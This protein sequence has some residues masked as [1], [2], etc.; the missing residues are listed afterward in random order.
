MESSEP[1]SR[2]IFKQIVMFQQC[3]R[4]FISTIFIGISTT[5]CSCFD[6]KW[7][8]GN[9]KLTS[10]FYNEYALSFGKCTQIDNDYDWN[11]EWSFDKMKKCSINWA[12]I[13]LMKCQSKFYNKSIRF[14]LFVC[15]SFESSTENPS[16]NFVQIFSY[17][18]SWHTYLAQLQL[19]FDETKMFVSIIKIFTQI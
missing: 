19:S 10:I 7:I 15:F 6:E 14:C 3:I 12:H 11:I 5:L 9:T 18:S 1:I 2:R 4:I 16:N 17:K 13:D 8:R